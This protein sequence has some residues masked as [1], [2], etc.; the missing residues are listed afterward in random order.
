MHACNDWNCVCDLFKPYK[1]WNIDFLRVLSKIYHTCGSYRE[2]EE[3]QENK[4]HK[5]PWYEFFP[6]VLTL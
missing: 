3:K 2:T 6:K 4:D 5:D 1:L